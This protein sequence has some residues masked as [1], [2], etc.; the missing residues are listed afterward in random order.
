MS[1]ILQDRILVTDDLNRNY[2]IAKEQESAFR[3]WHEELFGE[4]LDREDDWEQ[5]RC[6]S[7]CASNGDDPSL[8]PIEWTYALR[9]LQGRC[10]V[11]SRA[12]DDE[13]ERYAAAARSGRLQH[14][15]FQKPL[16]N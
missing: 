6:A 14:S 9:Q 4:G 13:F 3:K 1:A 11:I 10:Y 12:E 2:L 8:P 5:Y 16:V 7:E 15:W